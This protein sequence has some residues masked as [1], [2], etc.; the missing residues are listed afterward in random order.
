MAQEFPSLCVPTE[1]AT[2]SRVSCSQEE[3]SL[4][5]P[6]EMEG[7]GIMSS[8]LSSE[9]SGDR[10]AGSK[11]FSIL[12]EHASSQ[13][14]YSPATWHLWLNLWIFD[15]LSTDQEESHF[16]KENKKSLVSKAS[17]NFQC[18]HTWISTE[19]FVL[20]QAL[21]A[22][23]LHSYKKC[24]DA[25]WWFSVWEEADAWSWNT[26]FGAVLWNKVERQSAVVL[27]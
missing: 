24:Y 13:P 20:G 14:L 22:L 26:P 6:R 21:S 1:W 11:S 4:S 19:E 3:M 10:W 16:S 17:Y 18:L 2:K 25:P 5:C 9:S 15:M 23:E 7:A 8:S 27:I 12:N